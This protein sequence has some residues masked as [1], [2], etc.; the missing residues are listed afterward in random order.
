MEPEGL[1][2]TTFSNDCVPITSITITYLKG[3][4]I[5]Q[6]TQSQHRNALPA[7]LWHRGVKHLKILFTCESTSGYWYYHARQELTFVSQWD[8]VIP[9]EPCFANTFELRRVFK[10][11]RAAFGMGKE[12]MV[13]LVACVK[14]MRNATTT[15]ELEPHQ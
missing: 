7:E 5:D 8:V 2:P 6:G 13:I 9:L 1:E 10:P 12:K 4:V 15:I 11:D 14:G 3:R